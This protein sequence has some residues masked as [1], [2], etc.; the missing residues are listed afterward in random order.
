MPSNLT[1]GTPIRGFAEETTP[2]VRASLLS[3]VCTP[4]HSQHNVSGSFF[5]P[6]GT[7]NIFWY[8]SCAQQG[9]RCVQTVVEEQPAF[10]YEWHNGW[11]FCTLEASLRRVCPCRNRMTI[12]ADLEKSHCPLLPV[13]V[14]YICCPPH[15]PPSAPV[16]SATAR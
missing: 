14:C 4:T 12:A 8:V 3:T 6:N 15:C 10:R 7:S 13:K 16:K 9:L 2:V 11:P 1:D 5:H